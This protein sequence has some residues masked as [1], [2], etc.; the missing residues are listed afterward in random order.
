MCSGFFYCHFLSPEIVIGLLYLRFFHA[1]RIGL[2]V[3]ILF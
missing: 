3:L 1:R 2:K